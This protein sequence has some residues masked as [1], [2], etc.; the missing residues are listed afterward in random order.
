MHASAAVSAVATVAVLATVATAGATGK[1]FDHIFIIQ[2]EN[3]SEN[4]VLAD[5]N[6]SKCVWVGDGADRRTIFPTHSTLYTMSPAV[7]LT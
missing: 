4:E 6:F 7:F 1:W 2:F 3:H 5:P